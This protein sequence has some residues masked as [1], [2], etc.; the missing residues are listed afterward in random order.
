MMLVSVENQKLSCYIRLMHE[1]DANRVGEIDRL[2]FPTMRP[3]INY[4]NELHNKLAHY[5]VA[6][7]KE[8]VV[9]DSTSSGKETRMSP[10]TSWINRLI[11]REN[12]AKSEAV[13]L[14]Q[15]IFGFA[16]LWMMAD[17]AHIINIA[18]L[19][20]HRRNGI[21]E[22]L[23][24]A[25]IDLATM[26]KARYMILE[27][28]ASNVIA[29]RLYIKYGFKAIGTRHGYYTDNGEDAVM[30]S[31]DEI[32]SDAFKANLERLRGIHSGRW[33]VDSYEITG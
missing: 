3:V 14:K 22:L 13:E 21:G 7:S 27:A 33:G 2:V 24:I 15:Y 20:P 32:A 12:T 4:H 11:N 23:V 19:E 8:R 1:D 31:T 29:Q 28:R 16:G 10:I 25:M 6:C 26:L 30:M 9:A 18:V 17:E 5:V